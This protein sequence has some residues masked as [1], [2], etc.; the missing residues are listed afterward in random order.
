MALKV[1][2][3]MRDPLQRALRPTLPAPPGHRAG[4]PLHTPTS[5]TLL[6]TLCLPGDPGHQRPPPIS[7]S[8]WGLAT[9]SL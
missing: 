2:A 3:A 1:E 6:P 5:C 7:R 8:L 9:V 4:P